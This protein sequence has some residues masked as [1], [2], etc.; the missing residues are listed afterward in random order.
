MVVGSETSLGQTA[1]EYEN[2]HRIIAKSR[3]DKDS[4]ENRLPIFGAIKC[5][6]F[7][8]RQSR[9]IT[10][11]LPNGRRFIVADENRNTPSLCTLV[12]RG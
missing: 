5:R 4:S 7:G 12:D 9:H 11:R 1:K 3:S 8:G 6:D 10:T 2:R